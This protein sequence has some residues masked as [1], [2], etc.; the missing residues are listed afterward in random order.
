MVT[1]KGQDINRSLLTSM[2]IVAWTAVD[3]L[4]SELTNYPNGPAVYSTYV[5]N[6]EIRKE[7]I[8]LP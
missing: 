8:Q 3:L 1:S 6:L 5:I 4:I 2:Q 7:Q